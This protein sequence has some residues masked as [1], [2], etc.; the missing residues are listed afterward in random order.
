M[1]KPPQHTRQARAL[2]WADVCEVVRDLEGVR[3]PTH[4]EVAA[5]VAGASTKIAVS[6]SGNGLVCLIVTQGRDSQVGPV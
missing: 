2:T 3:H 1:I 6:D 4:I 5:W